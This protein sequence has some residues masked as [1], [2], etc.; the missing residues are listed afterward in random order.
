MHAHHLAGFSQTQYFFFFFFL[1]Y[2][3]INIS[4]T[5]PIFPW[6]ISL[7][8]IQNFLNEVFDYMRKKWVGMG[9][10]SLEKSS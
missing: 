6:F 4:E 2:R 5:L 8:K 3:F 7:E 9:G 10:D 1:K